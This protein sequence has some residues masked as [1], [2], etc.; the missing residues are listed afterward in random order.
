MWYTHGFIAY[1][2][3]FF[4]SV[5]YY[6]IQ[7]TY[8]SWWWRVIVTSCFGMREANMIT[9]FGVAMNR[10]AIHDV[11]WV[12][13]I[14]VYVEAPKQVITLFASCIPKRDTTITR[15]HDDMLHKTTL[16][17]IILPHRRK[18]KKKHYNERLWNI[19]FYVFLLLIVKFNTFWSFHWLSFKWRMHIAYYVS[20]IQ[21]SKDVNELSMKI[22]SNTHF[23]HNTYF[24]GLKN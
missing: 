5:E 13:R 1:T 12:K 22:H 6:I 8:I 18:D 19:H 11:A 20:H 4:Q 15:H 14:L 7:Y 24:D 10:R 9:C 16:L 23:I 17:V 21:T 2:V 3:I